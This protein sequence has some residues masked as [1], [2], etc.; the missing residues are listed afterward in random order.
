MK[1]AVF[2]LA[3]SILFAACAVTPAGQAPVAPMT[4][5]TA[6]VATKDV[7]GTLTYS[8]NVAAR[9]KVSVLPKIVGQIN[10]MNAEIGAIV[11]KGDV[12]AEL[13]HQTQDAQINQAQAGVA[14]AKSKL[15]SIQAGARPE[16]VVQ[17]QANLD[18]ARANLDFMQKGG[19]P[20]NVSAAE[21]N[22]ASADAK[23]SSLQRGRNEAV[24]QATAS[25][26]AAQARLQELKNG[27]T[28]E[29]VR[30][31]ELAVE[32]AKDGAYAANVAKDAACGPGSPHAMC[33]SAQAAAFAAQTGVD[34]ATSR[35]KSLMS[36]PTAEQLKEAQSAVDAANAQVQI[37]AHPGS[38]G[39]VA[40]AAGAIQ[41]AQ[42]QVD[43]A[44]DPFSSADLAKAQSA[45]DVADQQLKLAQTPFTQQDQDAAAAAV[46][47]A[48]AALEVAQVSRDQA[49][50]RSPID[51]VVADKFLSVGSMA[52]PTTPIVVLI[53]A[54]VDVVVNVDAVS[55]AALHTGDAATITA[56]ALPGKSIPGK[57]TTIAPSV[58][59]RTRT[60]EIKIAPVNQDTGLKDGMLAQVALVT[61]THQGAIVAPA[62]AIVQRDGAPTV[63]VVANGVASPRAVKTGLTDGKYVEITEGLKPGDEVVVSGQAQ[64]I[65]A[66]PVT[67]QK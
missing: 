42:A 17:A 54:A 18:A 11:K 24:A 65:T 10:A 48:E 26:Q 2:A 46:Q 59:Q 41:A 53:D 9:A 32:Q 28:S 1:I 40:A 3:T 67:V 12:L 30:A 20:E 55:A 15:A 61:A 6:P 64:L 23:L 60:V 19:R 47:Q 27:P 50:V 22:L 66:Q 62:D 33:E 5:Q 49:I 34:Q 58:D 14:V 13:D 63:Y 38:A 4:V 8:G 57:V 44:R 52:A 21:G 45:V 43:L 25:L 31:G 35:L 36:P 7:S 39:D 51:G 37:A 29:Q 16:L 56:D